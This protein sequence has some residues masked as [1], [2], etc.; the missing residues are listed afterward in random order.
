MFTPSAQRSIERLTEFVAAHKTWV[1]DYI[2]EGTIVSGPAPD[3][4]R[5]ELYRSDIEEVLSLVSY[6]ASRETAESR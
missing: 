4:I 3:R 6:L 5:G 1:Q 2:I